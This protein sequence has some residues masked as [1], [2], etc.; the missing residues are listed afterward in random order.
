LV[1]AAAATTTAH[2]QGVHTLEGRV[3]LP[4]GAPPNNPVKV[5]LTLNGRR[6]QETFTDLSGRFNFAGL[7]AGNYQLTAEG[8]GRSFET[9]SVGAALTAFRGSQSFTQNIQLR[10]KAAAA[11]AGAPAGAVSLEELDPSVPERARERYRQ[12][13]REAA[14]DK[15]E[16]AVKLFQEALAAHPP[17]YAAHL[18]VA[19]QHAKLQRYDDALAAY[20]KAGELKPDRAEP[21]VGIGVT[22]VSQKR[23]DEGIRM[24]RAVIEVDKN[25]SAPYLS[26]GY[27]EMMTG[28]HKD[29]ETH[30]LRALELGKPAIAHIYLANVYEQLG[31]PAKAVEHLQTY[32][33][34]NPKSPQAESVRG[35]IDKLLKKTKEK[36]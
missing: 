4:N 16:Q 19:E 20:R 2:A 18:G 17:F 13:L 6:I 10:P 26:L 33:K 15:P 25:L 30:L 32:L 36:K 1:V 35:A 21:Y 29:A 24:L 23:Y 22:L 14:A 31:Q 12:A 28:Q 5:T 7:N 8:D 11:S 3:Q 34:E 9:T 27:A